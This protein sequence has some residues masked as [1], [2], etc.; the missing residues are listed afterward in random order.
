MLVDGRLVNSRIAREATSESGPKVAQV[1][2][3]LLALTI[4]IN[5]EHPSSI[6]GEQSSQRPPNDLGSID[7]RHHVPFIQTDIPISNS[8]LTFDAPSCPPS[9]SITII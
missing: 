7:D 4:D 9:S 6:I 1:R 8:A 5:A 3:R 2:G